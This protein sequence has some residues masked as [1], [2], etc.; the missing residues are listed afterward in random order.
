MLTHVTSPTG[1]RSPINQFAHYR[2]F[3]EASNKTVVGFNVD[4]LYSL[5][6]TDLAAEPLL[7]TVP[8][9]GDRYWIMQIIDGWNNVPAAPGART[10]GGAGGVFGLVGPEW[11]GTLPDGVTRIDVPTSIALIG[12]RIYTAGPDDYAAV[13]ALQDQLSLVPLSAWGTHYTPPT[14]V[15]LEPG[16]QDTPVPAQIKRPDRGGVLQPAQRTPPHEPTGAR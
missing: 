11:E 15:P 16:V 5:A 10:V 7:L 9:M 8:P 3:P 6:Q 14:D 12:G 13:H 4:T 2:T 1:A